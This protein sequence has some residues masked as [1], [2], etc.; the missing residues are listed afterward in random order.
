MLFYPM[1]LVSRGIP[2]LV[3]SQRVIDR[4]IAASRRFIADETGEALVGLV[5]PGRNT[6][7]VP[8]LYVLETISPVESSKSSS[9]GSGSAVTERARWISS[10]VVLPIAETTTTTPSAASPLRATR[11]AT[12]RMRSAVATELP[13]YFCT[14]TFMGARL[15]LPG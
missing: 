13:P 2:N 6:N 4:M 14:S 8:T 3:V 1:G 7:G 12:A 11:S 9:R 5:V 15:L 10:S